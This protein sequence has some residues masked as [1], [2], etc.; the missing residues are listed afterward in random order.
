M[1]MILWVISAKKEEMKCQNEAKRHDI[2]VLFPLSG[3]SN[4]LNY[5]APLTIN[6]KKSLTC[7]L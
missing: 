4:K 7:F 6:K 5:A 2:M 1:S 3:I